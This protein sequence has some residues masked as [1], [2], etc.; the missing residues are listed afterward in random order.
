[1]INFENK[2]YIENIIFSLGDLACEWR[3]CDDKASDEC[4]LIEKFYCDLLSLLMSWGWNDS[5]EPDSEL[6]DRCMPK[7]Y[8]QGE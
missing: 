5:L 1:M 8:L 2:I 3:S 6:P 7:E 4:K